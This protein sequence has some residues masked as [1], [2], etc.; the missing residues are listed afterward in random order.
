MLFTS[1]VTGSRS[2][3]ILSVTLN[4][5]AASVTCFPFF[6][7]NQ[8]QRDALFVQTLIKYNAVIT[9][10]PS[11][12]RHWSG[13][14]AYQY[15]YRT[16]AGS[17][18]NIAPLLH[19]QLHAFNYHGQPPSLGENTATACYYPRTSKMSQDPPA[20][21]SRY[22]AME[23]HLR[24]EGLLDQLDQ[25]PRHEDMRFLDDESFRIEGIT[26]TYPVVMEVGKSFG[27]NWATANG[28]IIQEQS[29]TLG[30]IKFWTKIS[31][32][33]LYAPPPFN[34]PGIDEGLATPMAPETLALIRFY[35][36]QYMRRRNNKD[37]TLPFPDFED[38]SNALRKALHW[39]RQK[40]QSLALPTR[41][42]EGSRTTPSN[43]HQ[44]GIQPAPLSA[45]NM[46][47]HGFVEV[48]HAPLEN[49]PPSSDI[50]TSNSFNSLF[51]SPVKATQQ[52]SNGVAQ[53]QVSLLENG[54]NSNAG[55]STGKGIEF[56]S[57]ASLARKI[58]QTLLNQ[59]PPIDE[60]DIQ[61]LR[62]RG[63]VPLHIRLGVVDE[64][65]LRAWFKLTAN[66]MVSPSFCVMFRGAKLLHQSLGNAWTKAD[67]GELED[68]V[69]AEPSKIR[70]PFSAAGTQEELK[71]L[72]KWYFILA[73][74]SELHGF[75]DK[76]F[77]MN[78]TM[79]DHLKKACRRIKA[80]KDD[81]MVDFDDDDDDDDDEDDVSSFND[82]PQTPSS[83]GRLSTAATLVDRASPDSFADF[84]S[85]RSTSPSWA[86]PTTPVTP[87]TQ[88]RL[89]RLPSEECSKT[90]NAVRKHPARA[91]TAPSEK[92]QT[93]RSPDVSSPIAPGR[94]A[95]KLRKQAR[96]TRKSS[97]SK[98]SRIASL[99]AEWDREQARLQMSKAEQ[100]ASQMRLNEIH[101]EMMGLMG[102][103]RK[104]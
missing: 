85:F 74:E 10:N 87:Q 8:S 65:P 76:L 73:A 17:R 90:Q 95:E 34:T 69:Q 43:S 39:L 28:D 49:S 93:P 33:I 26:H 55:N 32:I 37:Q 14:R 66:K 25:L 72:C 58:R 23:A 92:R 40:Q 68:I 45:L 2:H 12:H 50:G 47:S 60:I 15:K 103:E 18:H 96:N 62:Q 80:T 54:S 35:L 5:S 53:L 79:V 99:Q 94:R 7:R 57:A 59:L 70:W 100:D 31:G 82:N 78:D 13:L 84:M 77:P 51:D 64:R 104:N 1:H 36:V 38:L 101:G 52:T 3:P 6:H 91:P 88:P 11:S 86:T 46:A 4:H 44:G 22:R 83:S 30:M 20:F 21:N 29:G 16:S 19:S 41:V 98:N 42:G 89:R 61:P 9:T 56:A 67:F 27:R 48:G 97:S 102:K 63:F 71:S 24:Q 81:D 75:T